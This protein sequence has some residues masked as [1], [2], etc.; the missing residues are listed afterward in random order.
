[1]ADFE[2]H[3]SQADHNR[4]LAN[5]LICEP[6]YHDWGITAAFYSAI[7]YFECWLY[8]EETEKSKKHTETSIPKGNNDKLICSPHSWREKLIEKKLSKNAFKAFRK[9][10][11]ASETAR[12]LS[13]YGVSRASGQNWLNIPASEYISTQVARRLFNSD[14]T[15]FIQEL[16]LLEHQK[17]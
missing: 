2:V 16:G 13:L 4:K 12:Y 9:L 1:M 14:L 17:F 15:I 5:K 6:P 10:R 3:Y 8:Q 7:H 11:E